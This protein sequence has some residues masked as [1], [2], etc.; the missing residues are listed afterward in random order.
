MIVKYALVAS[1]ASSLGLGG[2]YMVQRGNVQ[3]Q[4]AEIV[5]LS[6]KLATCSARITNIEEDRQSDAEVD[7]WP[8]LLDI[9]DSWYVPQTGTGN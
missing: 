6:G 3:R 8:D 9:P 5:E 7:S 1:L 2:A 4:K